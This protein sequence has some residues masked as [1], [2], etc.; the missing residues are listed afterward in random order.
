MVAKMH[1]QTENCKPL[2]HSIN[3]AVLRLNILFSLNLTG[4]MNLTKIVHYHLSRM[5]K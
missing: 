1:W 2:K 3:K 5:G 4:T